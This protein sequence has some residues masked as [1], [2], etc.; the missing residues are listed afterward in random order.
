MAAQMVGWMVETRGGSEA[1]MKAENL[2]VCLVELLER[3]L[4]ANSVVSTVVW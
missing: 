3:R 2:E 1:A 4:V